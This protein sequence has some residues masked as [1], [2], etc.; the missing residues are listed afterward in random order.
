MQWGVHLPHL[1]HR[2]DR[3]DVIECAREAERLGC[4]SVWVSDHVC[5]P[6]L[7]AIASRYPYSDDGEF[8]VSP[9][10]GWLDAIGTLFF[11]ATVTSEVKLATSVLVLPYRSPVTTAKQIAS[12]DILSSGRVILGVGVGWMAEEAQILGMPWNR[13]G[14]RSDEQLEIFRT[15]FEDEAPRFEGEFYQFPEDSI[16]SRCSARSRCGSADPAAP[17]SG[18]PRATAR[19]SMRLFSRSKR[20]RSHGPRWAPRAIASG[21]IRPSSRCHCGC[22]STRPAT[23]HRSTRWQ[24]ARTRCSSVSLRCAPSASS[25]CCSIR[26]RGEARLP[27][28]MRFERSWRTSRPQRLAE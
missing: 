26:W 3:D 13:R 23:C 6:S 5:W 12:L 10:M 11:V 27:G 22:S 25:T 15:L 28:S 16:R 21:A 8:L 17:P 18:A 1:G 7:S 20:W 14:A 2:V 24:A 4:H 9:D 19:H